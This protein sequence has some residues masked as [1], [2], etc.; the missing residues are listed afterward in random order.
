MPEL[1]DVTVYVEA[2]QTRV[3]GHKLIRAALRSPVLVRS[4]DPP[5]R[6]THDKTILDVRRLGKQIAIGAAGD[7]WLVLHLKIAGRLHWSTSAPKP[8]GRNLLAVFE[9]DNG[10]LSLT[11]TT[12]A[13]DGQH[14][15][16]R[17]DGR[18]EQ[19]H[20]DASGLHEDPAQTLYA[21]IYPFKSYVREP[22]EF[23]IREGGIVDLKGGV[24][25]ILLKDYIAGFRRP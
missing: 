14:E 10:W 3:K 2:L 5:L 7:L 11:E 24:D 15:F 8:A 18:P 4:A 6:A 25:A 23:T 22:V 1:P 21:H 16:P 12:R 17:G 20:A 19:H 13:G 9:F